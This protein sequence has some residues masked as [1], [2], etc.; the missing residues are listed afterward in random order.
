MSLTLAA[1]P[2]AALVISSHTITPFR[3]Q[4]IPIARRRIW[5]FQRIDK[6]ADRTRPAHEW[7]QI[8]VIW[9]TDGADTFTLQYYPY[10]ETPQVVQ[11]LPLSALSQAVA[12]LRAAGF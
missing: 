9:T 3:Y 5:E 4:Y 12:D 8:A 6:G 7:R 1:R 10:R 2:D 11:E